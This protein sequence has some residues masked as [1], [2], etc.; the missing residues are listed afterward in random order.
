MGHKKSAIMCVEVLPNRCSEGEA[1]G[2][3]VPH[4]RKDGGSPCLSNKHSLNNVPCRF[5]RNGFTWI[6]NAKS[7]IHGESVSS[8]VGRLWKSKQCEDT[9]AAVFVVLERG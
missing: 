6:S 2:A 5:L 3:E 1:Q 9:S 8:S 4:G 7:Q